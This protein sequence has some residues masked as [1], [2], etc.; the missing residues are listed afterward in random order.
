[1]GPGNSYG[2]IGKTNAIYTW[3]SKYQTT[4]HAIDSIEIAAGKPPLKIQTQSMRP[5]RLSQKGG[6]GDFAIAIEMR[7]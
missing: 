6:P 4:I 7:N 2:S 5:I 1:L 3:D